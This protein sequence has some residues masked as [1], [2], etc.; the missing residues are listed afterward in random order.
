MSKENRT[1]PTLLIG[2][3]SPPPTPQKYLTD[4]NKPGRCPVIIPNSH[5]LCG[6][7]CSSDAS[8]S[9]TQRCCPTSCGQQCQR[10]EGGKSGSWTGREARGQRG[11]GR[12]PAK[13]GMEGQQSCARV[14]R[15]L[16][17][18]EIPLE[19]REKPSSS[20]ASSMV[21]SRTDISGLPEEDGSSA[22][23]HQGSL[24]WVDQLLR[25]AGVGGRETRCH[26]ARESP[27]KA[28]SAHTH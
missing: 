13:L 5:L 14:A 3:P 7:R 11:R 27:V 23:L 15:F 18:H 10:P 25:R 1:A 24:S 9:G 28:P 17:C 6:K 2:F 12:M 8:C 4:I 21:I 26:L 20:E 16:P 19:L 22:S